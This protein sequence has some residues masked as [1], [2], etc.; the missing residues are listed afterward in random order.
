M[1]WQ[2]IRHGH[3]NAYHSLPWSGFHN[4]N[5]SS[6]NCCLLSSISWSGMMAKFDIVKIVVY[7][8]GC[9]AGSLVLVRLLCWPAGAGAG[10]VRCCCIRGVVVVMSLLWVKWWDSLKV[11]NV[12]VVWVWPY[13]A[14]LN[15]WRVNPYSQQCTSRQYC[16]MAIF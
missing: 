3:C 15:I 6:D 1:H 4:S 7:C 14:Q 13:L 10:E 2:S 11:A 9:C 8:W 12:K 16:H 5:T